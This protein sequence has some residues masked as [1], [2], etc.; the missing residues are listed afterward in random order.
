MTTYGFDYAD[1]LRTAAAY[2]VMGFK[3]RVPTPPERPTA[4]ERSAM[5]VAELLDRAARASGPGAAKAARK[6]LAVDP[7]CAE[8][9]ILLAR[10]GAASPEEARDALEQALRAAERRLGPDG[11]E[12]VAECGLEDDDAN[13]YVCALID[14][15]HVE[16]RLGDR[17]SAIARL[18]QAMELE[19][20][21][22]QFARFFLFNYLLLTGDTGGLGRLLRD[23]CEHQ[24]AH[25]GFTAALLAFRTHGDGEMARA[26]LLAAVGRNPAVV[27]YLLGERALPREV[28]RI[29]YE[30]S[31]Y[32]GS[33]R[34][35]VHY[36]AH[37]LEAWRETPGALEWLGAVV[38]K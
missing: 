5:R 19:S 15:A 8:A 28:P 36:A 37:A 9:Y 31:D 6:A 13:V 18:E 4:R 1:R 17:A 27:S 34:E 10:R 25:W 35:A 38:R 11:P 26:E 21:D 32:Y 16:W 22:T 29:T 30:S 23:Y 14:L 33:E 20:E 12:L 3:E 7:D 24:S 2:L